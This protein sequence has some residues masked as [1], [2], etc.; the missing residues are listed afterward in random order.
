[1][2]NMT[3]TA[4]AAACGGTLYNADSLLDNIT[5][6]VIDSRLVQPGNLFIAT[7]GE[8]VDGH[9]YIPQA[10]AKGAMA[11][12]GEW[13]L[14]EIGSVPYIQ[15][16]DSFQALKD[17]AAFYR[18]QLTIPVVGI[19]GSVGKTSTKEFIA[20]VLG[21]R[22]RVLKTEGNFNNEVGLPLTVLRIRE[23]HEVAVLEM[24]ISDFGEMHRLAAIACP[25][26]AVL[27]NIGPCHLENL[28]S[29][30]G[31]LQAK[32]EI[33]THLGPEGLV[34]LNGDDERLATLDRVNEKKPLFFGVGQNNPI[35]ADGI[36][37]NGLLGTR[38]VIHQ[39]GV[40]FPIEIPL[41]GEHMIYNALAAV[42]VGSRLG[43][44]PIEMQ[45]GIG[46]L[47]AVKGRGN[48]INL[49]EGILIDDCYNAN[50]VSMK[51]A[52][53]LLQMATGRRVAILG[54]MLELGEEEQTMHE[55][56]GRYA[57]TRTDRL[58][59]IGHRSWHMYKA[60][61][62][63]GAIGQAGGK[64]GYSAGKGDAITCF[65]Y[66]DKEGFLAEAGNLLQPADTVLIKASNGMGFASLVEIAQTEGGFS[67]LV[68]E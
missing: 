50:P 42:S 17:I 7:K 15:V 30:A 8:K 68:S 53:D 2:K 24:G 12:L 36:V 38:A 6:V 37:N 44:S 32:T 9:C 40:V 64:S 67:R 59:C 10:Q 43:L 27:T 46:G 31:V 21:E 23:Q 33:F 34:C 4:I 19:T 1:M 20:A 52:L 54:D 3:L 61:Q 45:R 57:V 66:P 51:A 14:E 16:P 39:E 48:I 58:I 18:S 65:Y 60:A 25:D 47:K 56:I 62:E 49:P 28:G 41:P 29:L 13:L 26:I 5:G 22:Y 35:Y 63:G 11:V 55:T